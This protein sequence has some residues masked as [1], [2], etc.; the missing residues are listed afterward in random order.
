LSSTP[1]GREGA[2]SADRRGEGEKGVAELA[3][4]LGIGTSV[5]SV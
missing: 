4:S 1:R 5:M 3:D 2:N